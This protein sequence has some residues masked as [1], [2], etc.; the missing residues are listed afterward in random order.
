MLLSKL[1]LFINVSHKSPL[2]QALAPVANSIRN[3][4][5]SFKYEDLTITLAEGD[6]L[7]PKP[8]FS[9]L[10]FGANFSDHMLEVEWSESAGWGKPRI[11]P[12]HAFQLHPCSKVL[13]YAQSVFEGMKAFKY[14]NGKVALFRPDMNM[15]RFL[16]TS[17][18]ACLPGFNRE[19]LLKCIKKLVSIDKSWIPNRELCSLY[20]RPNFIGTEDTL[21][22]AS[23]KTALLYVVSGPVGPYFTTTIEPIS[24]LADPKHV[25]ACPGGVGCYKMGSN[26]APT[27]YIQK[28]AQKQQMDQVLW[29]YGPDHQITE[30]GAMNVFFVLKDTKG[31]LELV[32]PPLDGTILPGVV[33][34]SVLDLARSLNEFRVSERPINMREIIS[35]QKEG[36]LLEMFV[37]GTALVVCPVKLI[38]FN[39]EDINIPTMERKD[40]LHSRFLKMITDIQYGRVTSDWSVS[41]DEE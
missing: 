1:K 35:A 21:G 3:T 28:L 36:R 38:R 13:H 17:E 40:G 16:V 8:D 34:H 33:R 2:L 14:S 30:A 4:H 7:K 37:C 27:L 15:N 12:V 24:L 10:K 26:Y 22:V 9:S 25:R 41:V 20:I 5:D 18:R 11:L 19:E 23:A 39:G 32:T 29:L 6:K 31:D